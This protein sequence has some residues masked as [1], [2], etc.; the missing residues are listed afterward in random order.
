G[1]RRLSGVFAAKRYVDRAVPAW[2]TRVVVEP[3][4]STVGR[5]GSPHDGGCGR[6]P[7][8]IRR[9]KGK[10]AGGDAAGGAGS[11]QL[12]AEPQHGAGLV[13]LCRAARRFCPGEAGGDRTALG[14]TAAGEIQPAAADEL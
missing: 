3:A 2:I 5:S 4:V 7:A 14:R 11:G 8:I 6:E 1:G 9:R 12:R 13:G 10:R